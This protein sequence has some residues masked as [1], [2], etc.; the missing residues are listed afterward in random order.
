MIP[1]GICT[2]RYYYIPFQPLFSPHV[3]AF[4]THLFLLT[5]CALHAGNFTLYGNVQGATATKAYLYYQTGMNERHAD[6][7]VISNG[8]FRIMGSVN[9]ATAATIAIGGFIEE[10]FFEPGSTY[11]SGNVKTGRLI[12][13][14]GNSTKLFN[15]FKAQAA[16]Y[17]T[18]RDSLALV[19]ANEKL[20]PTAQASTQK[21]FDELA[22]M[23]VTIA[24]TI[25][26]EN[27]NSIVSAYLIYRYF[28]DAKN[29][30][31][32]HALI[33]NLSNEI[34]QS[35]YAKMV[36]DKA[37]KAR[38]P[39]E[40]KPLKHFEIRDEKGNV[41]S[42]ESF[43]GKYVLIDF[44]ASWCGPCR[45]QNPYL[46]EAYKKYKDK[47]F[48]VLGV[49]SDNDKQKWLQAIKQDNMEWTNGLPVEAGDKSPFIVYN[50]RY[51]PTNYLVDPT[52]KIIA[53]NLRS[54]GIEE[55]LAEIFTPA[56]K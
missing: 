52:G 32:G 5:C 9:G 35:I 8:K 26:N 34:Q 53:K 30:P 50:V 42:T 7:A 24:R 39:E 3:K 27:P 25:I 31:T 12:F 49:S 40:G 23:D 14:G 36:D 33:K 10:F 56:G 18:E 41:L 46:V 20:N 51:I 29:L 16:G 47:G 38:N 45:M 21:R 4:I 19:L 2:C 48:E 15:R 44:W 11:I 55:K 54:A 43:L 13:S 22:A 1:A 37:A 6:S 28:T 17:V